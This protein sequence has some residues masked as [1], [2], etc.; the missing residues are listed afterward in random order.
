MTETKILIS[1]RYVVLFFLRKITEQVLQ[2]CMEVL[3]QGTLYKLK[4]SVITSVMSVKNV[5][6]PLRAMSSVTLAI[7]NVVSF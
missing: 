4:I 5:R 1:E 2:I 6:K 7:L 3:I